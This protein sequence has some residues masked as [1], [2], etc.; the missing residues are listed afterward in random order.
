MNRFLKSKD[1]YII[2]LISII[3]FILSLY[4]K[5][6][7]SSVIAIIIG[8][9]VSTFIKSKDNYVVKNIV[10]KTLNTSIF[11]MGFSINVV[12][13]IHIG[14]KVF[15]ITL[16]SLI[17]TIIVSLF[18]GKLFKMSKKFTVLY[19]LGNAICG[20]SAII[21]SNKHVNAN[22]DDE[23]MAISV[24]NVLGLILMFILPII[25]SFGHLNK[26]DGS[27]MIG[28]TIQSIGQVVAGSAIAGSNFILTATVIKLIRVIML[29]VV[30]IILPFIFNSNKVGSSEKLKVD[31]KQVFPIF[32]IGFVLAIIFVNTIHVNHNLLGL[33]HLIS[34]ILETI[35]LGALGYQV[36][37]QIII[38]N[39]NK[40][41]LMIIMTLSFQVFLAYV[42]TLCI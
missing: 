23:I 39:I 13:L 1:T 4:L 3:S 15:L 24:A 20:S 41:F 22:K 26:L 12:L 35:A 9:I 40:L 10:S 8:I 42:L 32:L 28:S 27:F 18:F 19:A 7:G 31:F 16:L 33:I 17:I 29:V 38:K 37:I 21:S 5:F 34:S 25:I 30:L 6:L 2:L 11:T 14:W 36:N